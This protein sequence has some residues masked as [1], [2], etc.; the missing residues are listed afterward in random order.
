M[1]RWSFHPLNTINRQFEAFP[2]AGTSLDR[3]AS[4]VVSHVLLQ[5]GLAFNT[6]RLGRESHDV[7]KL[8]NETQQSTFDTLYT[9]SR[10]S[11]FCIEYLSIKH[12]AMH[13]HSCDTTVRPFLCIVIRND[14]SRDSF[15]LHHPWLTGGQCKIP[16]FGFLAFIF[17]GKDGTRN[18]GT[19]HDTFR[20][21]SSDR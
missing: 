11:G 4:H 6:P 16:L 18:R 5:L 8:F 9:S 21:R 3:T 10:M 7:V 12:A 20:G 17:S 2:A 13:E 1:Q 19:V 14:K 15:L